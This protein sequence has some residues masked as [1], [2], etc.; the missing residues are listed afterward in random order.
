MLYERF[1]IS[2]EDISDELIDDAFEI[3]DEYDSIYDEY[4]R[5]ELDKGLKKY[6]EKEKV[7]EIEKDLEIA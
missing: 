3:I 6:F 4:L 7:D 2:S 5:Y 1:N